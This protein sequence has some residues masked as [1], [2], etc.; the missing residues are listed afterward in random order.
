M[1]E[2][3]Y[4]RTAHRV[5]RKNISEIARDTGHSRNTIR[6]ALKG[7]FSGYKERT[8][9]P[10]PVLGDY[11]E[12]IDRWLTEDK[13]RPKK[14][15]HTARRIYNRL[16]NECGFKGAEATVRRYVR[17]AK[18]RLGIGAPQAFI[19]LDPE[20]GHELEVDWGTALAIIGEKKTRLK[21]CCFRSKLSGKHFLRFYRCERQQAF[22]DAH[23]KAFSFFGGVFTVLIYDNLTTAV[24]K[25]LKGKGRVEQE[26]FSKFK[27][28]YNFEARFCNPGQGHEKGGVEGMVGFVRRNYMVPVPEAES[29]EA[30]NQQMLAQCLKYGTHRMAGRDQSVNELFEKEKDLLIPLP[31][32]PFENVQPHEGK[33]DKY[34]TVIV[35]KNRYSVPYRY[36]GFQ[37]K[38][39]L[40]VDSLEIYAGGK[41]LAT[42]E[43]LYNNNKWSLQPDHYLELIQQR[44]QAFEAAR[45]IRQWREH[46]PPALEKLLDRFCEKQGHTDG[47]KDFISVLML[48]K[49][50]QAEE[51]NAA[52]E[53]VQHSPV[54][55]SQS[56]K[57]LL[58]HLGGEMA[59]A[60]EPLE[61]WPQLPLPDISAFAALEGV[62]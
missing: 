1:A 24:Q 54:S 45:P 47:I 61:G 16:V 18:L 20:A 8:H 14:Q 52:V 40:Y 55:S 48:Y 33:V 15:R 57:H 2:Y 9:Q 27:A 13:E 39:L 31:E 29:L 5:Y 6:K 22:L 41:R 42:H 37:V 7:E 12:T 26:A 56:I 58:L 11:I 25:V 23:I 3:E 62:K 43:R 17:C 60:S 53:L 28:Y 38:V 4:I 19:P 36:A 32:V 50:H 46:W 51:V 44:P 49:D 59:P 30:L 35:D 34:A 21:Y 10:F